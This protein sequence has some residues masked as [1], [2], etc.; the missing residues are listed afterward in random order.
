MAKAA[1]L[2]SS[3][4]KYHFILNQITLVSLKSS[5]NAFTHF[6]KSLWVDK[7]FPQCKYI[8]KRPSYKYS[9]NI[10][11]HKVWVQNP[12][13]TFGHKQP[14]FRCKN[15]EFWYKMEECG[16]PVQEWPCEIC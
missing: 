8:G 1:H 2:E 13:S 7:N 12:K 10:K 16:Y 5:K 15:C 14:I 11:V 3:W 6:Y 4:S 9:N